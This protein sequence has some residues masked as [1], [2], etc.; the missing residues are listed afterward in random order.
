LCRSSVQALLV[1]IPVTSL[2]LTI[3]TKMSDWTPRL[4]V[5][6]ATYA[7]VRSA[8]PLEWTEF[9]F[10][11]RYV[12]FAIGAILTPFLM[13]LALQNH[14]YM[15]RSATRVMRHA[16]GIAAFLACSFIA[17]VAFEVLL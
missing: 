14:R 8:T 2:T 3:A 17:L 11:T 15:D 9:I 6:I 1:A 16:A 4:A 7:H 12:P 5:R 13:W 10:R